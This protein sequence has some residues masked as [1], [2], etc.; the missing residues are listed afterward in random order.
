[1]LFG[2]RWRLHRLRTLNTMVFDP[3]LTSSPRPPTEALP[4][5]PA[6][7]SLKEFLAL[8]GPPTP[9]VWAATAPAGNGRIS[10]TSVCSRR[11][12][13][14][15]AE[16]TGLKFCSG[17]RSI[18]DNR[19]RILV[20]IAPTG[21]ARGAENVVFLGWRCFSFAAVTSKTVHRGAFSRWARSRR[22]VFNCL[23]KYGIRWR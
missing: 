17:W 7:C 19:Y 8:F 1:M 5:D 16:R 23:S 14:E 12:S 10:C 18:P 21:L 22:S 4:L 15:S 9:V 11:I 13:S 20:A 2:R 6:L 3:A